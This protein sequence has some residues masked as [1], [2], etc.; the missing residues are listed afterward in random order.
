MSAALVI[1]IFSPVT[2]CKNITFWV[3]ARG[4]SN[5]ITV[6]MLRIGTDRPLQIHVV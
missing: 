2:L 4:I 6:I 5:V 1:R 3:L